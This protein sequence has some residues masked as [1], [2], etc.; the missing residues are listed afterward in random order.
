MS[1][2]PNQRGRPVRNVA[3][4]NLDEIFEHYANAV[5]TH[6]F[7]L[8]G[9]KALAE[10]L[11]GETFL[12]AIIAIE[13]FRGDASLK[14]WLLRIARNLYLR[15]SDRE[16]RSISLE[17]LQSSGQEFPAPR[18]FEPENEVL[19]R[20]R[21][22]TIRQALLTLSED[23]RSVLVLSAI[24]KIPYKEIARILDISLPAVKVRVHRARRRLAAVLN[25]KE[26]SDD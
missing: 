26:F 8:S 9:E 15:R 23:D 7:Y 22:D 14:T 16:K 25:R 19:R 4:E 10:D 5:F 3:T 1:E 6:L 21:W 11:T 17:H 24:E 18:R 13:D 20:E 2:M 12:R